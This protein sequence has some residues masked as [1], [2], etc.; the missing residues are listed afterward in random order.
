[1]NLLNKKLSTKTETR[2]NSTLYR[3]KC[4]SRLPDMRDV[5]TCVGICLENPTEENLLDLYNILNRYSIG[6]G[7]REKA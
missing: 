3:I 4:Q 7:L 2:R 5:L 1:M 6:F